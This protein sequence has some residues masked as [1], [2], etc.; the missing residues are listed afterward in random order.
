MKQ[1]ID[2]AV[3][4]NVKALLHRSVF[5]RI[6]DLTQR[7][8]LDIVGKIGVCH[9]DDWAAYLILPVEA[10]VSLKHDWII[11]FPVASDWL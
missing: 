1:E 10:G 3:E 8:S 7:M 9:T 11:N 2:T 4:N 6:S 5:V